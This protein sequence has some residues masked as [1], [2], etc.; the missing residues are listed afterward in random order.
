MKV[1]NSHYSANSCSEISNLFA[2]MFHDSSIAKEFSCGASKCAYLLCFGLA[3]YFKSSV[4]RCVNELDCYSILFDESLNTAVQK[5]QMDIYVRFWDGKE[6]VVRTRYYSSV[7]MGHSTAEDTLSAICSET[8][9]LNFSKVVNL[10]MDG[11]SVNWKVFSLFQDVLRKDHNSLLVNVGSCCL[12]TLNNSFKHGCRA[13]DW[14]IGSF[15]SSLYWLFKDSP[16]R[17]EDYLQLSESGKMPYKFCKHRWLENC[18]AAERAIEIIEEL[19]CYKS[20][21]ERKTKPKN[22]SYLIVSEALKDDLLPVKLNF[23]FA[24]AKIQQPFLV[25]YQTDSPMLPFLANDLK[26]LVLKCLNTFF[27]MKPENVEE[28]KSTFKLA[29]FDFNDKTTYS[30]ISKI[31][32]GFLGDKL[33]KKLVFKKKV[34]DKQVMELKHNCQSF[35]FTMIKH[36]VEKSPIQYKMVRCMSSI[37]PRLMFSESSDCYKKMTHILSILSDCKKVREEDC[38]SI[39][40]EFLDFLNTTATKCPDFEA[41]DPFKTRV[42]KFLYDQIKGTK[43]YDKLWAVLKLLLVISHGQATVERGFSINRHIEV[44]NLHEESYI[45][46]RLVLDEIRCCGGLEK[47]PITK[48]LRISA[49]GARQKYHHYLDQQSVRRNAEVPEKKRKSLNEVEVLKAK[50]ARL[51]QTV[52]EL[53]SSADKLSEKA[54]ETSNLS[55]VTQSN[56]FRRTAKEKTAEIMNI[57]ATIK[58]MLRELKM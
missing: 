39:L 43:K 35:I 29:T 17:R 26:T 19:K 58:E 10:S 56:S 21:V 22:K 40:S 13:T 4:F 11:P 18:P 33:L 23:F 51:Q 9:K 20:S 46:R 52:E 42:D 36:L 8:N 3:P 38:D 41:F 47:V 57:D 55:F 50:R 44:E 7:F 27:V 34:S 37:D 54:E 30:S 16:A 48:E 1:V 31:S 15:L 25:A 45:A 24:V 14:D 2:S 28:L 12:H 32:T 6:N 5:K 49:R 53:Q